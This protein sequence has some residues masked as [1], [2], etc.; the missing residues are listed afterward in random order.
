MDEPAIQIKDLSFTY[1]DGTRALKGISVTIGK[2]ESVGL[3]GPNGAGKS[4]LMLHLNGIFRGDG[5]VIICGLP[6]NKENLN[7]IRRRV[8]LVFQDSDDQLFMP[9]VFDDVAFGP[10]NMDLPEE[11]V[12][13]RV[14]EA[15]DAVG[16]LDK[17]DRAPYHLSGGEK[18][19]VALATV[20]S[21][22]PKILALDEPSGN[23]DPRGRRALINILKGLKLTKLIATH[24]L[25]LVMEVC[26]RCV[27]LD[28]GRIV[29]DGET[30]HILRDEKLLYAHGLEPP[31]AV[32]PEAKRGEN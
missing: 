29:A 8:G 15:L 2:G 4:T 25:S 20:L 7:E 23:L 26:E 24:D 1:P 5:S 19:R 13:R 11:E 28:E 27:L 30:R 10:L 6:V 9:T 22:N 32:P 12:L 3:I 17:K 21:M 18:K 14:E 31:F 16:M